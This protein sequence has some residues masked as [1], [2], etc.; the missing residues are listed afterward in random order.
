[1]QEA[2]KRYYEEI[3]K[4]KLNVPEKFSFPLDV[5]D[6]WGNSTALI[7][8][9]G[10]DLKKFSFNELTILSSKLAGGLKRLGINKGDRVLILLP[11]IYEWWI[12][13]L[14]IMRINAVA[15]P[16]TTLLTAKDIEY[17]LKAADIKA[18]ISNSENAQKI[19][20]AENSSG[21]DVLLI[22]LDKRAGWKSYEDLLNSDAFIGERTFADDPAFI[23]FTS[24]T[25][26]LPKMVLHTQVS[27]PIGH[28]IT[29]KFW[30]DLKPGD[31]HWNLSDTGWAKAAWSSF[32]GPWNMGATIFSLYRKGKFSPSL[33]VETL[34]K[35]EITTICGPPT[36][37]RM[38]VKELPLSELK[39]KTVRHFVAAGE[40]LNPEIIN[41]WKEVTGEYIYNGYGQ[42]ETV[43]TIAM[44]RFFPIKAGAA[45][46]PTPGYNIDIVDDDGNPL[47]PNTEGNIAIKVNPQKPVGLFKEYVGDKLEM[48]AVFRGEWYYTRDR[49]YKDEDGYFWFV[50]REDDVIISAGYRIGPFEVESALIKHPA[51]KEAAVVASPD[52]VRGEVVKAL[53]VLTQEYEPSDSLVKEIQEFVKKETAPYKYPRKIEFVDELPKTISGKIKRKELKFKEFGKLQ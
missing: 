40:P 21:K 10:I 52:E 4:F 36:A 27:Y 6:R 26:G 22:N 9:D 14:A 37:Y 20:D 15:I 2:M 41:I 44:L 49:G 51:V 45:G 47:P 30:L 43:N 16:G 29:G 7:W 13:L 34:K 35:Y 32:L 18:V 39:F 11:N 17:R 53:I 24:G 28:I 38:I 8:T 48:S 31:I 33:I 12:I 19:E 42:T 5:F 46:L 23:F 50:G 1:M 3:Q 25:T